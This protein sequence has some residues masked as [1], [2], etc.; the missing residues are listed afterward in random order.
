MRLLDVTETQTG[1]LHIFTKQ[2]GCLQ[3]TKQTGCLQIFFT[4]DGLSATSKLKQ[5]PLP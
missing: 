3:I 2:I 1:C 4:V 5:F